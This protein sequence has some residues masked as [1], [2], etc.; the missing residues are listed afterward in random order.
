MLNLMLIL[1]KGYGIE[2]NQN[3]VGLPLREASYVSS[4]HPQKE[5]RSH[6]LLESDRILLDY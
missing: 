5:Q 6:F 4:T 1:F 2:I 3:H